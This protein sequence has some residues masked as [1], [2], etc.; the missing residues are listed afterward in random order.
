MLRSLTVSVLAA[1][2]LVPLSAVPATAATITARDQAAPMSASLWKS[3]ATRR[4]V[5]APEAVAA[6]ATRVAAPAPAVSPAPAYQDRV[7][8]LTNVERTSR[9]LAPLTLSS[10]A[11]G[12]ADRWAGS[13]LLSGQL[14]H[15]VLAPI[16]STCTARSVGENVAFGNVTPEQLVAMWMA[17]AGHRANIL[18]STFNRLGVGATRSSTGRWYGVQVF[19]RV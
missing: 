10:C 13:L 7:L 11:D 12:F 16:L 8:A 4:A 5:R 9:G 17:S 18:N 1:V 19:L 6:V 3:S 14:S 2:V 15:Q